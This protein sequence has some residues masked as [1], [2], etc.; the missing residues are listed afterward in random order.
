MEKSD[1]MKKNN[2]LQAG[3]ISLMI[4]ALGMLILLILRILG[5]V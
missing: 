5:Y 1:I 2:K 4:M 3:D